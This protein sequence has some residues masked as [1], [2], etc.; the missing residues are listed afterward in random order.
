MKFRRLIAPSLVLLTA[1]VMAEIRPQMQAFYLLTE[2][3]QNYTHNKADYL[4]KNN[5]KEIA[6]TLKEFNQQV[7]ELKK[8]KFAKQDDMKFRMQQL[9][10][11]L[12]DAEIS[13]KDGSKDYSYWVLKSTLNN[14]YVCHTQKSL[15]T[16]AYQ[17]PQ[18]QKDDLL[19]QADF[20]FMVRNYNDA[21]PLLEKVIITYPENKVSIEN[22]ENSLRKLL[23]HAVRVEKDDFKTLTMFDRLLKNKNLPESVQQD[24]QAWKGYLKN[25]KFRITENM[26]LKNAQQLEKFIA[27]R[28]KIASQ[29]EQSYQ[30]YLIDLETS[31]KLYQLLETNKDA[32]LKPWILYWLAEQEKDYRLTMFDLTSEN[33]L[34]ECIERYSKHPAAKKCFQLYKQI[35]LDSFTGSRGTEVP[36]AVQKQLERYEKLVN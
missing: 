17:L 33:Y 28:E 23:M 30:S 3:L 36:P 16:T 4:K 27:A 19:S 8:D 21:N 15:G 25:R 22:V 11:G 13:F 35:Q 31:Q 2:K 20:L 34:K 6:A 5:E 9:A 7:H 29:Y 1:T 14:C 18:A 32:Q 12:E 10:S 26:P 24:I